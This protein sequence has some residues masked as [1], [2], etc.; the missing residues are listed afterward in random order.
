MIAHLAPNTSW[1]LDPLQL[2]P[3]LLIAAL[4]TRR[5]LTLRDPKT[6][7]YHGK[8]TRLPMTLAGTVPVVK[9][10]LD[11]SIEGEYRLDVGSNSTVDVHG[12]FVRK[13]QRGA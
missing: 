1:T 4:Y 8:G 2:V 11:H 7:E 13:H 9:M 6:F 3:T 5:V 10:T 12:P